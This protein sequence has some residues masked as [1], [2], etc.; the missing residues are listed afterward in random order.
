MKQQPTE[1][2]S[3]NK[4]ESTQQY[5]KSAPIN[6]YGDRILIPGTPEAIEKFAQVREKTM[7]LQAE[8]RIKGHLEQVPGLFDVITDGQLEH[9]TATI[10]SLCHQTAQQHVLYLNDLLTRALDHVPTFQSV[11]DYRDQGPLIT[12]FTGNN[13]GKEDPLPVDCPPP[14]PHG[15]RFD[16]TVETRKP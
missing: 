13:C 9:L 4:D 11:P 2:S 15:G 5:R 10:R 7:R 12:K 6:T 14:I 8:E 1:I 16:E 3:Q